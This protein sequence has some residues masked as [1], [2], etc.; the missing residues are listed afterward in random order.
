[1]SMLADVLH[2]RFWFGVLTTIAAAAAVCAVAAWIVVCGIL[3]PQRASAGV[4]AACFLA[5]LIGGVKASA[6]R[7]KALLRGSLNA[8][9]ALMLLWLIGLTTDAPGGGGSH[10][11]SCAAAATAGVIAAALLRPNGRAGKSRKVAKKR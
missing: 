6:G 10:M 5:A 4:Y 3:P 2:K 9:A 7:P 1:M 8:A 11:L